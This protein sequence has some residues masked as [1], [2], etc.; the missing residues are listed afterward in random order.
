M[1]TKVSCWVL[2]VQET[3]EQ[4]SYGCASSRS[5]YIHSV[6]NFNFRPGSQLGMH[7]TSVTATSQPL[8]ATGLL[9]LC[10]HVYSSVTWACIIMVLSVILQSTVWS[11]HVQISDFLLYFYSILV[12]SLSL[13]SALC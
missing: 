5:C 11:Q 2:H 9:R 3:K 6:H 1:T 8:S 13:K 7:R 4:L 10:T 12:C